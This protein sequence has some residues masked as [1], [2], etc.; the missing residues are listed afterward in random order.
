VCITVMINDVFMSISAVQI[1]DLSYT[2]VHLQ[3]L[4]LFQS[5]LLPPISSD[6]FS[7]IWTIINNRLFCE[8]SHPSG[9]CS[10][11]PQFCKTFGIQN[12]NPLG[13]FRVGNKIFSEVH[14]L[15]FLEIA[16]RMGNFVIEPQIQT[17]MIILF[18]YIL[19]RL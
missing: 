4:Q 8:W 18:I 19:A 9:N 17:N 3:P 16:L 11:G 10:I 12:P 2:C 13:G 7:T 5:Q 1:Y 6:L 14:T 15:H